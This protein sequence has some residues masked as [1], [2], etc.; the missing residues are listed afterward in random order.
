MQSSSKIKDKAQAPDDGR[1]CLANAK[2]SVHLKG[3]FMDIQYRMGTLEDLQ[4]IC[5]LFE[6]TVKTMIQNKIFQWDEVYPTRWDLQKDIDRRELYVGVMEEKI[7]VVYVINQESDEQYANG[8]WKHADMP[9]YVV[10]RL[11]V[12]PI[13]QKQGV[14]RWTLLHIEEQLAGRGIHAIRLDA[15]SKNPYALKLY[16][17]LGYVKVG[18]A[19]WR[20]GRFYLMEKYT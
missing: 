9:Y 6:N 7:A 15:F 14:A 20:K 12:H 11:C 2:D 5:D 8:A 3:M 13:F 1:R 17:K 10:H 19:D 18:H 16:E 4:E